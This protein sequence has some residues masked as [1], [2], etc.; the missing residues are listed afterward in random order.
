MVKHLAVTQKNG[1]SNPPA[2]ANLGCR[3]E[4]FTLQDLLSVLRPDFHFKIPRAY[5][6][7]ALLRQGLWP[8]HG[9]R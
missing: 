7:P 5:L 3:H 9:T 6:P 2:S 1:G 8:N 4:R